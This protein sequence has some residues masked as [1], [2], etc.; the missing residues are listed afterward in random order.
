VFFILLTKYFI[1]KKQVLASKPLSNKFPNRKIKLLSVNKLRIFFVGFDLRVSP[2]T[3]YPPHT[4]RNFGLKTNIMEATNK[5]EQ[6]A[7]MK[8]L[9]GQ[10][11]G[12]GA[13]EAFNQKEKLIYTAKSVGM[14]VLVG[15][16]AGGVA[17]AIAGQYSFIGGIALSGVGYYTDNKFCTTMGLGM[18]ASGTYQGVMGKDGKEGK[19]ETAIGRLELFAEDFKHKTWIDKLD[20]LTKKPKKKEGGKPVNG[21]TT[22][23]TTL[24]Q[25]IVELHESGL[26]GAE[27]KQVE[28]AI[29]EAYQTIIN[30]R[31]SCKSNSNKTCQTKTTKTTTSTVNDSLESDFLDP[32]QVSGLRENEFEE[33][34][35]GFGTTKKKTY[36]YESELEK[37]KHII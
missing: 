13:I 8:T 22:D 26:T 25:Q 4:W 12:I 35:K 27:E 9:L 7:N 20:K 3:Q 6:K 30:N 5:F 2:C 18:M 11:N 15:V 23:K 28:N 33:E 37:I 36:D 31:E 17:G 24:H 10:T 16:L 14:D 21:V 1:P 29:D 19:S 32:N 34:G